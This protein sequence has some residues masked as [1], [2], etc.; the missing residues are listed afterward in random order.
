V[1]LHPRRWLAL[2]LL[3]AFVYL[4]ASLT[5]YLLAD[6]RLQR[7]LEE[8]KRSGERSPDALRSQVVERAKQLHV[9]VEASNVHVELSGGAPRITVRY[10][11]RVDLP[12]YTVQLHFSPTAGT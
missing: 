7:S 2:V 5:P 1:K 9:P 11:V 3:A 10:Q 4:T 12:G 8:I 6:L